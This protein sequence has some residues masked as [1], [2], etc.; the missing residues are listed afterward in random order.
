[1]NSFTQL[2]QHVKNAN[3]SGANQVFAEIMQQKVADRL[4]VERQTIFKEES[5]TKYQEYFRSQLKKHGYD[6]PADIPADKKDDF[7]NAVDKG[8][9]AK[10][11]SVEKL[12]E[13]TTADPKTDWMARALSAYDY[14]DYSKASRGGSGVRKLLDTIN[15]EGEKKFGKDWTKK[16]W[17]V[18]SDIN[19]AQDL[20]KGDEDYIE[21]TTREFKSAF[22]TKFSSLGVTIDNFGKHFANAYNTMIHRH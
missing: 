14:D 9:K 3:W 16:A 11:E 10:N 8:Y 20:Y 22:K 13:A 15:A 21:D 12:T 17:K 6:S 18:I 2:V 7:F 1:M 19:L 4:S 5:D